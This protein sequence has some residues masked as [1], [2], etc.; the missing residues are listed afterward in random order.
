MT[1]KNTRP[2]TTFF[3][4]GRLPWLFFFIALISPWNNAQSQHP[5]EDDI[6]Q[7]QTPLISES[8]WELIREVALMYPEHT[9]LSIAVLDSDRVEFAGVRK[10]N[11]TIRKI[12]NQDHIFETGS[13]S[14]VFTALL[15]S[16]FVAVDSLSLDD[17][18]QET[19]D[20]DWKIEDPITFRQ[21]ANHTSGLPRLPSNLNFFLVDPAN[22]YKDYDE[23]MLT[24]Y[25][26]EN[27]SLNAPPG[28]RYEYSN[29]GAG[30][31]GYLL[32]EIANSPYE[33]LLQRLIVQKYGMTSTS[34]DRNQLEGEVVK[35]LDPKGEVTSY[36]DLN[37]LNGAGGILSTAEDLAR[38]AMGHFDPRDSVTALTVVPTFRVNENMQMG[39]GWHLITTEAGEQWT[40]HNGGTGGFTSSIALDLESR[41]GV[42]VLTNVSTFH[43]QMREIDNLCFLLLEA[44]QKD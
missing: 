33:D 37:I 35:G 40:W 24:S 41:A 30:L 28:S 16:H 38:F 26:A 2:H 25:L 36:W 9:Q 3:P 44:L 15:L 29:L 32:A 1:V 42:V 22:P 12:E 34:T 6:R 8:Q 4:I 17:I 5:I 31:L 43:P 14:K 11:D 23:A 7:N 20:L 13:V 21:L 27:M 18:I 10:T 19:V 39:L